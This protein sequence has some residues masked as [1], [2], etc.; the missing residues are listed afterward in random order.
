MDA[1]QATLAGAESHAISAAA[2]L[3]GSRIYATKLSPHVRNVVQWQ[4]HSITKKN[5]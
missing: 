5:K 4:S 2:D 1:A 3:P